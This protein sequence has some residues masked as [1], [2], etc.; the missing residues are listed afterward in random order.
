VTYQGEKLQSNHEE[1]REDLNSNIT[2]R[3]A[4]DVGEEDV[5]EEN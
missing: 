2:K 1:N 4:R 5:N 3:I